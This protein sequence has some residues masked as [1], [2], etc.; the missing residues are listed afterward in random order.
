M[1]LGIVYYS[2]QSI[3]GDAFINMTNNKLL[4]SP[5]SRGTLDELVEAAPMIGQEFT[6]CI[7]ETFRESTVI[8]LRK[9]LVPTVDRIP[10]LQ[11][12]DRSVRLKC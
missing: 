12:I 8:A 2:S 6:N 9:A 4:E 1:R 10:I 11:C 7:A 5:I 3:C